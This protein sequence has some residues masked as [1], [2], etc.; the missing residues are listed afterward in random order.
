MAMSFSRRQFLVSGLGLVAA[1]CAQQT[2]DW[3]SPAY[4]V[5]RPPAPYTPPPPPVRVATPPPAAAPPSGLASLGI[6]PRSS[7]AKAPP[8]M[9]RVN[10]MRGIS[11][12]T[13]HHEGWTAVPFSDYARTAARIESDRRTHVSDRGWGDLGY[14]F[15]VDRAGRIWEGRQLAYQGA[16]VKDNNEHN[17]GVMLLGN[18]DYQEPTSAQQEALRRLLRALMQQ[19]R[20]PVG[21][22]YTHQE[23]MP[24]R[25]PGRH[26]QPRVAALRS[27]GYLA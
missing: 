8:I 20:V 27:R 16:H 23:I 22:V 9:S 6:I 15:V 5:S 21:R 11:R 3:S 10:P 18:F 4:P 1:G 7:W 19:Y 14:H 26:L 25:C 13:V 2:A 17:A 24:T 12:I